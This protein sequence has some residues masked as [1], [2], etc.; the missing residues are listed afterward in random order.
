MEVLAA[1]IRCH[2]DIVGLHLPN[3]A[4]ALP[5][6]SLYADDTTAIFTSDDSIR[7]VFSIYNKF[8]KGTGSKLN[9]GSP[10]LPFGFLTTLELAPIMFCRILFGSRLLFCPLSI[11]PCCKP[12]RLQVALG[13]KI[14]WWLV[15]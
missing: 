2:P 6:L 13:P 3:V 5:V 12:G 10:C 9:L 8:E 7:A 11:V 15:L 1:N 14:N 4:T